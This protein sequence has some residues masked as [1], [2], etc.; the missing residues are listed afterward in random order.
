MNAGDIAFPH[1]NIYLK[2]VP[3]S[4]SV[5]G[6]DIAY[7]GL[8]IGIGFILGLTVASRIAKRTG[9]DAD[10]YWDLG[11]YGLIF[12]IIGARIY[13]VIFEWDNY[14]NDLLSVFKLREGGL[15]IY[16]GVIGAFLTIFIYAK[17]KKKNPFLL[18]DTVMT[19]FILGQAVGRWGNFM[20][21]EVF[22]GYTDNFLA[23]R[24]PIEAVR[25]RD[26][27]AEL[28]ATIGAG[29]NFIQVHPTFLYESM[30]NLMIFVLMLL[31][32]KHKRFDGELIL[33]YLAGYGA[34]RFIIE[35]IRTDTLFIPGTTIAV[36]QMLSAVL[37][38][39]AVVTDIA[40]RVRM[41]K[42]DK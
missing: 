37:V 24:L 7:Y 12:G 10:T 21:R 17:I 27:T 1:L 39:F 31:Y 33:L 26:I 3:K 13:Y 38:I 34:G 8:I 6:F 30:W 14:K 4:F 32:T 35:G 9:Q 41:K 16:G 20:N 22:G 36:S 15:A 40:V 18:G 25:S 5:F 19:G 29:D 28:A 23:M 11:I 2:N 42:A